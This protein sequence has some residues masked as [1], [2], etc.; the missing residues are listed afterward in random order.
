MPPSIPEKGQRDQTSYR[1]TAHPR[2]NGENLE[3]IVVGCE[4]ASDNDIA[5]WSIVVCVH[6]AG[7]CRFFSPCAFR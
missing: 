1:Q 2:I 6:S 4:H 3:N 5:V 7:R